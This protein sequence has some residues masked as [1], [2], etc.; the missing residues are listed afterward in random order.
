MLLQNEYSSLF[1]QSIQ[2]IFCDLQLSIKMV[3]KISFSTTN[4]TDEMNIQPKYVLFNLF[5]NIATET[6]KIDGMY[7]PFVLHN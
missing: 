1:S 3:Y 4:D 6:E 2:N 5:D 7:H